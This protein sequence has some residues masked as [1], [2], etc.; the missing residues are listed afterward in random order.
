MPD[1]TQRTICGVVVDVLGDAIADAAV[2][3]RRCDEV[4]AEVMSDAAGRFSFV[5]SSVAP[6]GEPLVVVAVA[7]GTAH[8][9]AS[10]QEEP[11]PIRV[12]LAQGFELRGC[13]TDEAGVPLADVDL[14][15]RRIE[16]YLSLTDGEH[17]STDAGGNYVFETLPIGRLQVLAYRDD[18]QLAVVE[19]TLCADSVL[20]LKLTAPHQRML[21]FRILGATA[22]QLATAV[23]H[24]HDEHWLLPESCQ[25]LQPDSEGFCD[26]HGLP[27]EWAYS[28]SVTVPGMVGEPR[29]QWCHAHPESGMF[30]FVFT[31]RPPQARELRGRLLDEHGCALVGVRLLVDGL[32][33]DREAVT[34]GNGEF[35]THIDVA[36]G[37]VVRLQMAPGERVL[38]GPGLADFVSPLHRNVHLIRMP[39]S[40]PI[41]LRAAR[42]AGLRGRCVFPD[43]RPVAFTTVALTVAWQSEPGRS[44]TRHLGTVLTDGAGEYAFHGLNAR[45]DGPVVLT[46]WG[47]GWSA[48]SAGIP[49]RAGEV[50]EVPPLVAPATAMLEG[51]LRDASDAPIGGAQVIVFAET[52]SVAIRLEHGAAAARTTLDGRFRLRSL[53]VGRW[54][55]GVLHAPNWRSEPFTLGAGDRLQ[56]DFVVAPVDIA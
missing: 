39:Q 50:V 55:L 42:A 16:G 4:L 40:A 20:D 30:E 11:G 10:V 33:R 21:R 22:E 28:L 45:V 18:R 6:S 5:V 3:L 37:E 8:G 23:C 53:A 17:T 12:V 26:M 27:N 7:A 49:L 29:H 34:N 1:E 25:R 38:D 46:V 14:R 2:M 43:G 36:D 52:E 19:H 48:A 56:R 47:D 31:M 54:Q 24:V 15:A 9:E 51:V 44:H 35:V 32:G 41:D 13:V